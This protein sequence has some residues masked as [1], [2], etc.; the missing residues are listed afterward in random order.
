[1]S[2]TPSNKNRVFISCAGS[3]KTTSIVDEALKQHNQR[4]LITTYTNEGVDQIKDYLLQKFGCYPSN[5]DV[6]SWF[7]FLIREGVRPY[8]NHM[9]DH[10]RVRSVFYQ[11]KGGR[12]HRKDDYF[13]SVNDIYS[14]KTS[15]FIVNCNNKSG[16]LIVN[17]LEKI[18]DHIFIDELQDLA[19]YDLD[20]LESLFESNINVLA[21][22]DPRQATYST[23]KAGRHRQYRRSNIFVWVKKLQA[24]GKIA[25]EE[26][27]TCY[28]S[29]AA[30]C[31]FANNLFPA[32]PGMVPNNKEL[33]GH[34]GIFQ[35]SS[36]A[37]DE[38]I[39]KFN[40]KVLRYDKR[41]DTQG[42]DA[43]NIGVSKGR[44]YDRVLIFPTKKMLKYL[45]TQRPSDAGDITKLYIAVTRARHSVAFVER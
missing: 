15:E 29:N 6:M 7:S 25:I 4:I 16:G 10:E 13:T 17:R 28:R 2:Q 22:G 19:S 18:Y 3:G 45:D 34:D 11:N 5:V 23:N 38:Y 31:E 36:S 27:N 39:G 42:H 21:V 26:R 44:T 24:E 20:F 35:I 30:I 9:G 14:N 37:V 40:P 41:I 8:Q 32:L 12:Y 33:T 1:M 43:I